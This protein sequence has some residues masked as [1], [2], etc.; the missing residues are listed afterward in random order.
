MTNLGPVKLFKRDRVVIG[1]CVRFERLMDAYTE[2]TL[3]PRIVIPPIM[4]LFSN[5]PDKTTFETIPIED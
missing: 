4:S 3:P 2:L 5:H 1:V